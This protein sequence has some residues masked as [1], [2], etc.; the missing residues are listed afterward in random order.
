[1]CRSRIV[2]GIFTPSVTFYFK[3]V[4]LDIILCYNYN[5]AGSKQLKKEA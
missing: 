2:G 1:M 5:E 3:S 4:F